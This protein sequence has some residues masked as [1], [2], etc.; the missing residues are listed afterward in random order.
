[1][2][3]QNS[4]TGQEIF[5]SPGYV[6]FLVRNKI[7]SAMLEHEPDGVMAIRWFDPR[8]DFRTFRSPEAAFRKMAN[9]K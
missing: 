4:V 1:M 2:S 8:I 3:T 6:V 9:L 7:I 5:I